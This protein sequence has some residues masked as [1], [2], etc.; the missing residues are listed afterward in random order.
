MTASPSLGQNTT[1][2]GRQMLSTEK[3]NLLH[4]TVSNSGTGYSPRSSKLSD[5]LMQQSTIF[6]T[7]NASI[8]SFT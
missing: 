2:P 3:E 6:Q 7:V 8:S 4:T 1:P 5:L